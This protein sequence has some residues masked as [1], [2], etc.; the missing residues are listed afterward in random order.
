MIVFII[1]IIVNLVFYDE[2]FPAVIVPLGVT[3][4][5]AGMGFVIYFF[6]KYS[7]ESHPTFELY[8]ESAGVLSKFW[9]WI[10]SIHM[11]IWYFVVVFITGITLL[12]TILMVIGAFRN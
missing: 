2:L 11:T 7:E 12:I 6:K 8:W 1:S 5:I 9:L 10:V 4:I 3:F